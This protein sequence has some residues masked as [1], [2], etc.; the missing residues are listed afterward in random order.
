MRI[1]IEYSNDQ[2]GSS[3]FPYWA[4][5]VVNGKPICTCGSDWSDLRRE[6]IERL[7]TVAAQAEPP[8]AEEIEI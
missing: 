1:Q 6:H 8:I 7:K 4:K 5:S 2:Q 3:N